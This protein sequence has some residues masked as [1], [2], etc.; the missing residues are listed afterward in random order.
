LLDALEREGA[1]HA[2]ALRKALGKNKTLALDGGAWLGHLLALRED[3]RGVESVEALVGELGLER[4]LERHL[5][6]VRALSKAWYGSL[7]DAEKYA[8]MLAA[9]GEGYLYE[10]YAPELGETLEQWRAGE[11]RLEVSKKVSKS[12]ETYERWK[13]G[14]SEGLEA[15]A[16]LWRKWK[17][18]AR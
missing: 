1:A 13:Q 8:A 6:G 12:Y 7:P 15:Y 4:A 9:L 10:G 17:L 14:W 16:K 5:D 11:K 3:F 18:P 2:A